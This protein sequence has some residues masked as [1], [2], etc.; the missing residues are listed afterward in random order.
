MARRRFPQPYWTVSNTNSSLGGFAG[1]IIKSPTA[2]FIPPAGT[3]VVTNADLDTAS[4]GLSNGSNSFFLLNG[5]VT[6]G[7][8]YDMNDDGVLEL[9][10]MTVIDSVAWKDRNFD[11]DLP[12]GVVRLPQ[13]FGSPDAIT[14]FPDDTS[15]SLSAWYYGDLNTSG[16]MPQQVNYDPAAA[17]ANQPAGAYI[18]PGAPNFGGNVASESEQAASN[19]WSAPVRGPRIPSLRESGCSRPIQGNEPRGLRCNRAI[20]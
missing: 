20:A 7:N 4:G 19:H 10:G 3:T 15:R 17:S 18:T 8:D 13:S 9:S 12:Y 11:N 2:G 16:F 14:R 6:K 5:S 1:L